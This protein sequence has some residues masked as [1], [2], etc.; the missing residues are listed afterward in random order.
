[1]LPRSSRVPAVEIARL[2]K[3][4]RRFV[5][6]GIT[7]IYSNRKQE[8]SDKESKGSRFAFVISTK[9]DKR[10]TVRNKIRRLLSESVRLHMHTLPFALDGVIIASKAIVGLTQ[11]EV[12]TR[13]LDLF[14]R[15]HH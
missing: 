1:M 4:G 14:G 9:V 5:G 10:A 7:L 3:H 8:T 2:M 15:I 13:V 11:S 12:E 6:N